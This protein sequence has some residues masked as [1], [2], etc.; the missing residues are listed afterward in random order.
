M[1]VTLKYCS[2]A[3]VTSQAGNFYSNLI[4][5][6]SL[7][8]VFSIS[9]FHL[10]RHH[11]NSAKGIS[12]EWSTC[13]ITEQQDMKNQ[14]SAVNPYITP[15]LTQTSTPMAKYF[16]AP[17]EDTHMWFLFKLLP[18]MSLV[19]GIVLDNLEKHGEIFPS[20]Q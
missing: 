17:D 6:Y 13:R 3:G 18:R 20:Y 2:E 10:H 1:T 5:S 15:L 8:I 9:T 12:C 4:G 19:L 14:T 11:R 16:A 7:A